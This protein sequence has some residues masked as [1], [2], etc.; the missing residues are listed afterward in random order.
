MDIS[1]REAIESLGVLVRSAPAAPQLLSRLLPRISTD[2]RKLRRGEL[3]LALR[4]ERFNGHQFIAEAITKGASMV[5]YSEEMETTSAP[6]CIFIRVADTRK[7]LQVLGR[8]VR[9]MWGKPLVAITG[10]VGKTT[11]KEFAVALL[12]KRFRT[13]KSEGNFN[14]DIGV[15]L[16]L[17]ELEP[18]HELAVLEL[19]MNHAGEIDL[20]GSLCLPETAVITGIAPVHL[21]F[22]SSVD[23]IAEAKGEI[24]QHL[25]VTGT[26]VYNAD[27][28]RVRRLA[29]RHTGPKI[30]YG[31][32]E[33]SQVR[34][35]DFHFQ[36]ADRMQFEMQIYDERLRSEASFVGRHFLYAVAAAVAVSRHFGI[37]AADIAEEI[38]SLKVPSMRGRVLEADGITIWDDSYNSN[39]QA[40]AAVLETVSQ[41]KGFHR[42][43][44]ALGEMRELGA[45]APEL[46]FQAG[47]L[48]AECGID[49]M[50]TVGIDAACMAEG[51]RERKLPAENVF[52]F[53]SSE[54]AAEFLSSRI[55]EGDFLLVKGS[56][57]IEMDR[58]VRRILEQ[59]KR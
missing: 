5:M 1:L 6:H 15:P 31:F 29:E 36:S 13:L 20:L 42:K 2:T 44:L 39:P 48:A 8:Q 51:A 45:S 38:Q 52:H 35:R 25:A 26:L 28:P 40:L 10:S 43:I 21:Q 46:H 27:D 54:E 37:S 32:S 55:D 33:D 16:T 56:R 58:I 4:G 57:S 19:G 18:K 14:N 41:L 9:Q 49:L 24:L 59:R 22:F 47:R 53:K 34:L 30:A 7:A 23:E 11:T 17:L 12:S 50:V 3:F